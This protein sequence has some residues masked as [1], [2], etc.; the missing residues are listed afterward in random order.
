MRLKIDV[1]RIVDSIR[2]TFEST[3][4]ANRTSRAGAESNNRRSQ[5]VPPA[6][7][8]PALPPPEAGRSRDRG[9]LPAFYLGFLFASCVSGGLLCAVVR[10]TRHPT[11]SVLIGQFEALVLEAA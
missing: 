3:R 1:E 10:S 7:F 4:A 9:R 11:P 2:A 6:G 8:E 5:V